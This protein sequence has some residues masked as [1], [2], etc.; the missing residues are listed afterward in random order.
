MTT[1]PGSDVRGGGL[2]VRRL[3]EQSPKQRAVVVTPLTIAP[4]SLVDRGFSVWIHVIEFAIGR[5][6][7]TVS[8]ARS[9][10][11]PP[12]PATGRFHVRPD[13]P[14]ARPRQSP[15]DRRRHR[16]AACV[17]GPASR[18]QHQ[19]PRSAG[20][21]P[22]P[23]L[24]PVRR[25]PSAAMWPGS[26]IMAVAGNAGGQARAGRRGFSLF[27]RPPEKGCRTRCHPGQGRCAVALRIPGLRRARESSP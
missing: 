27:R 23:E 21:L 15:G 6:L 20:E 8:A 2:L 10:V 25:S 3:G 11:H 5:S 16:R 12:S 26:R 9:L 17:Q 14:F 7:V 19:S 4:T 1:C 24:L 13:S 18:T 22:T